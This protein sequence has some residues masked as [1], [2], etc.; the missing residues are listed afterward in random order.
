MHTATHFVQVDFCARTTGG[1]KQ[2]GKACLLEPVVNAA[3]FFLSE[4]SL[5]MLVETWPWGGEGQPRVMD[6]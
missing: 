6:W 1:S 5:P 3:I 2:Q 4:E